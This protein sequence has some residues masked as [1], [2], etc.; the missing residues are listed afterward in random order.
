M[1]GS[2]N[3]QATPGMMVPTSNV[4][5]VSALYEIDNISQDLRELLVRLYQNLN[6]IS[7]VLNAKDTGYYILT[8]FMTSQLFF[9]NPAYTATTPTSPTLRSTYRKVINVGPLPNAG[10]LMVPHDIDIT[11]SYSFTRIYGTATQ[12]SPFSSIPL[13]FSSP[14]LNQNIAV[15]IDNAYINIT[16]GIDYSA[17]TICYI[18]CEYIKS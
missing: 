9:A 12:T 17:Y 6:N 4:W 3:S 16:T 5:D 2:F 14:T 13:P 11:D 1:A 7:L 15:T 18:V 10:T 8:E